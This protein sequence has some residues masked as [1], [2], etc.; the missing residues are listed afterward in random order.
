MF[1][2]I[3][4]ATYKRPELLE[5]LLQSLSKQKLPESVEIE[6]IIVDND[7]SESAKEAVDSD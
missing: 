2:S 4:I 6:V 3:C 7:K 5:I 1:Y